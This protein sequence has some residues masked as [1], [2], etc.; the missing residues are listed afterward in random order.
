MRQSILLL[1]VAAAL[2]LGGCA[3]KT[4]PTPPVPPVSPPVVDNSQKVQEE[5]TTPSVPVQP[6]A[7]AVETVTDET[8]VIPAGQLVT[9]YFD[10]DSF[11]LSPEARDTLVKNAEIL[12]KKSRAKVVLEGHTDERGAEN[13]NIALGE[14]RAN[15]VKSYLGDLGIDGVR[16]EVVS[17][18]EERPAVTGHDEAAWAKNRR[19]EFK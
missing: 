13:Y 10:Y 19:V 8:A 17:F 12:K 7:P 3:T 4:A 11:L 2:T 18:G 1:V 9:I 6:V 5:V 15:A 14:K 16:L